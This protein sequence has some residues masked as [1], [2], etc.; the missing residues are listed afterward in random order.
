MSRKFHSTHPLKSVDNSGYKSG[1]TVVLDTNGKDFTGS[2]GRST[3]FKIL[4][5]NPREY[6]DVE[7]TGFAISPGFET[8][9][10]LEPILAYN[11]PEVDLLPVEQRECYSNDDRVLQFYGNYSV[12]NCFMECLTHFMLSK[13]GCRPFFYRGKTYFTP[14]FEFN[15]WR[16]RVTIVWILHV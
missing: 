2:I 4:V 11:S 5:Q 16:L 7:S 1:L 15:F 12:S 3:G 14:I 9:A 6:P 13:C 10:G 8:F